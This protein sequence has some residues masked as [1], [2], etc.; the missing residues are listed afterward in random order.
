MTISNEFVYD[1]NESHDKQMRSVSHQKFI[2]KNL[3]DENEQ[4]KMQ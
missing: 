4:R 2:M 3:K 1:E